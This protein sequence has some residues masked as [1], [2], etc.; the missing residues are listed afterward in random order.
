MP[1]TLEKETKFAILHSLALATHSSRLVI[2]SAAAFHAP[3]GS[4][5]QSPPKFVGAQLPLA[6]VPT[7]G[8]GAKDGV[9]SMMPTCTL[10]LGLAGQ[11]MNTV[12]EPDR[13][14][15][16]RVQADAK[17]QGVVRR[18]RAKQDADKPSCAPVVGR[19]KLTVMSEALPAPAGQ[20][21]RE[22]GVLA[23]SGVGPSL[24][25]DAP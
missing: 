20:S 1:G 17:R 24:A 12:M 6:I 7:G 18:S 5:L 15:S 9:P 4:L 11:S 21:P 19:L 25:R 23:F 16:P 8:A 10:S 22:S 2:F 3:D 13:T 14:L